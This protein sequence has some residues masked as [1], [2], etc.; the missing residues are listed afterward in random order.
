MIPDR[1][2]LDGEV[3]VRESGVQ[4]KPPRIGI[5]VTTHGRPEIARQT[6]QNISANSADAVVVVVDD[7]SPEPFT[8][9][10]FEVFRYN[11]QQGIAKAKNKC[12]E[13]LMNKQVE[14]LFLFDDDCWPTQPDW[15]KPYIESPEPHLCYLFKDR[16]VRGVALDSPR[17]TYHDGSIWALEHPRGCMMYMHRSVVERIG[18]FRPEFGIW[19]HEH[20]EYSVR[21]HSAGMT[22]QP[23]Q[24]ICG[25]EKLVYS[26]DA[27]LKSHPG[28]ARS[29][30]DKIRRE[31]NER[32][33]AIL[34]KYK[35]STDYVDYIQLENLVM[36]GLFTKKSDPQRNKKWAAEKSLIETWRK[37]IS[38]AK[39]VVLH[40]ELQ[41]DNETFVQVPTGMNP[42]AQRWCSYFQYLREHKYRFVFCTDGTDVTMLRSPWEE[43]IPGVLYVGWEPT[44]LGIP[45][46]IQ[47]H[48]AYREWI[49]SNKDKM[50][51]NAGVV[52]GD[53]STVLEFC[54]DMAHECLTVDHTL[55]AGDMAAFNKVLYSE[56]WHQRFHTGP[57]VTT[58]F[59]HNQTAKEN[60]WS[61]F[62]H[63]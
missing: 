29:V 59:K 49:N 48:P 30:P 35:G 37:S 20:V 28:F 7:A 26:I 6:L 45:W 42:Y 19:G 60:S 11:T 9:E 18:G 46:M 8:H 5:A 14:H 56:K 3:Y 43:M 40:D 52:G 32:N 2:T 31:E 34:A 41:V 22:L 10:T 47:N 54:H 27:N 12:L 62:A 58:L 61:W 21:A 39:A 23:F 25:S 15:F 53:Y 4:G 44:I 17:T 51:L 13:I 38:D 16:N 1:I 36:T 63:K 50:L 57:A 24:D 55:L 33:A